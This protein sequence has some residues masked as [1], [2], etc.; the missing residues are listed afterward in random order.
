MLRATLLVALKYTVNGVHD[1]I[2]VYVLILLTAVN[3]K[4]RHYDSYHVCECI[5]FI[6]QSIVVTVLTIA[7]MALA[8][9]FI[10]RELR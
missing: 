6:F 4:V 5:C 9:V 8:A 1:F 7:L 2:L 3:I 10:Y